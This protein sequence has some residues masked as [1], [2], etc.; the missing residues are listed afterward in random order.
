[1]GEFRVRAGEER[2]RE[3]LLEQLLRH[4]DGARRRL[5]EAPE[6]RGGDDVARLRTIW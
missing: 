4:E 6:R 3:E 5:R 2:V 1:M